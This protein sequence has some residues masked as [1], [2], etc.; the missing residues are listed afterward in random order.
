[1]GLGRWGRRRPHPWISLAGGFVVGAGYLLMSDSPPWHFFS[2]VWALGLTAGVAAGVLVRRYRPACARDEFDRAAPWLPRVVSAI[3][4]AGLFVVVPITAVWQ[5]ATA[6]GWTGYLA[7]R[8]LVST[9]AA[10]AA[11]GI[12]GLAWSR[13]AH[14]GARWVI[15]AAL[16][17]AY[18][19]TGSG[20]SALL[21]AVIYETTRRREEPARLV[22]AGTG[23]DR[24]LVGA[25]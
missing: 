19:A 24:I 3:V 16:A 2:H 21:A 5:A 12:A 14:G 23:A 7:G 4:E 10:I 6:A 9:T 13:S 15:A 17:I 18:A 20:M 11:I 1:M 22:T 8:V 25:R